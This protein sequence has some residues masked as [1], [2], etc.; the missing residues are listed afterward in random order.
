MEKIRNGLIG[1]VKIYEDLLVLM[2]LDSISDEKVKQMREMVNTN[3]KEVV[4]ER[5]NTLDI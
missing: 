1:I 4:I 3:G 5:T 2:V